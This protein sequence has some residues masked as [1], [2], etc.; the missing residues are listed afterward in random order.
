MPAPSLA[1]SLEASLAEAY[2]GTS[3]GMAW[4]EV[5]DTPFPVAAE[6]WIVE[7]A[8]IAVVVELAEV[9]AG[10]GVAVEVGLAP[11]D[12]HHHPKSSQESQEQV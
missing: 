8:D 3:M 12:N 10:R 1:E 6:A 4:A 11:F 9:P 2:P 5:E 7:V